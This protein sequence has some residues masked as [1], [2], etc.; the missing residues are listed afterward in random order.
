MKK[1]IGYADSIL[2]IILA[3][4]AA[5]LYFTDVVDDSITLIPMIF[6]AVLLLTSLISYCPFYSIFRI[7]TYK[8]KR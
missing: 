7:N 1:N 3:M 6:A 5:I 4:M 8:I 2:R